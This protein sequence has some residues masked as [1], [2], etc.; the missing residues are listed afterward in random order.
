M[1]KAVAYRLNVCMIVQHRYTEKLRDQSQH[2][3]RSLALP[4]H[5]QTESRSEGRQA[6]LKLLK[7]LDQWQNIAFLRP[8]EVS[9]AFLHT[10]QNQ[11]TAVNKSTR[12]C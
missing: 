7:V 8:A 6:H 12:A 11:G 9:R 3:L 1:A 2:A 5:I 10:Q 4:Q